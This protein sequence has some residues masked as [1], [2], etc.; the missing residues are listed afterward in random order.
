[1]WFPSLFRPLKWHCRRDRPFSSRCR[2]VL[3]CWIP[4][5]EALEDRNVPST[6]TVTSA[7]DDGSA[8]TLRAVVAAAHSGDTIQFD[9]Q[10][11]GQ[12][13][14]LT[15]GQLGVNQ[16]LDIDGPGADKLTISGNAASRIF[17]V[18]GGA[19]VTI[20]GLTITQGLATDGAGI[21]NGGN[22]TLSQ[23]VLSSN[24]A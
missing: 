18:S 11:K 7:G 20:S 4:R 2:H 12:T 24:T 15:H 3:P 17:D 14:T 22:L 1:M 5:L 10:L 9:H 8:G 21:L 16:S 19:T 23:D 6:L 13:I